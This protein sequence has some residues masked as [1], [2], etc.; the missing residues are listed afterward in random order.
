MAKRNCFGSVRQHPVTGVISIRWFE[1][2]VRKRKSGFKTRREAN[3]ALARIR[4]GLGDGTLAAKRKGAIGFNVAAQE[5][6]QL[7]SAAKL[8]REGGGGSHR[9]NLYNYRLHIAP[10]FGE[11]PLQAVD[12][13]R[14][15]EFR[16]KLIAKGL[17]PKTVNVILEILRTIL[18]F[19]VGQE[20][21]LK[22][23]IDNMSGLMLEVPQTLLQ[24]PIETREE[25][26]LFL[27]A[28]KEL[29]GQKVGDSAHNHNRMPDR[30]ALYATMLYTGIRKGE[31]AGL[32]WSRVDFRKRLMRIERSFDGPTK[33]RKVREVPI[34]QAL[35]TILKEHR[36]TCPWQGRLVFPSETGEMYTRAA[37]WEHVLRAALKMVKTEEHPDGLPQIRIH[38]LRHTYAA[39]FVMAGGSIMDLS[40]NLGHHSVA[41]TVKTY[42]HLSADHRVRQA[43]LLD[44]DAPAGATV[45]PLQRKATG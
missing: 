35:V 7:H 36:R 1:A 4:V 31:A 18:R 28:V 30:Y 45:I 9:L 29:A 39:H 23:P 3:E 14:I 12:A 22:S 13:K 8:Q 10:F 17:A 15:L 21:L 11:M 34:P 43:D 2:G 16:A 37:K 41:F 5:W 20:H 32:E 19:A 25:V 6:L 40:K 24:P 42:G 33:S 44:Y 38:D 27:A 26:A